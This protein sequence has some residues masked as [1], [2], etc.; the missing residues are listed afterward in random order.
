MSEPI[1][2]ATFTKHLWI[3]GF[4][5]IACGTIPLLFR[6]FNIKKEQITVIAKDADVSGCAKEYDLTFKQIEITEHNYKEI[7]DLQEGDFVLNLS[8]DVGCIDLMMWATDR[9]ALYLDTAVE[10]WDGG[11]L[12]PDQTTSER[13]LYYTRTECLSVREYQSQ[14]GKFPT[15]ITSH[16]ANPGIVSHFVKVAL[17]NIAKDTGVV[18]NKKPST[19]Q[20]W[21][22]LSRDLGVKTIH[23]AERDTQIANIP[24]KMGE[25]QSTWSVDGFY[26]ESIQPSELGWGTNEKH[27]PKDGHRHDFGDVG[28]YLE[29]Q[30]HSVR[31]RSWTPSLGSYQGYLITHNEAI[32]I[33]DYLTVK[34]DKG[35]VEYRP[36]VQ[37][38]YL[39]CD[40]AVL[41][42][43]EL[44][45]KNY[46]YEN[47]TKRLLTYN[48]VIDGRDELGVLVAGHSKNAY[49]F[50]S[51]LT[52][53]EAK[54]ISPYNTATTLQVVSGVIGGIVYALENPNKGYL[55]C[56]EMD[57]ERI[58]EVI[59]PFLGTIKGEY[60]DWTPL[61]DRGRYFEDN[62]LDSTDP[63]QFYNVRYQ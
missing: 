4:G 61:T 27:F 51:Q 42:M 52:I 59:T 56:E 55:E 19:K 57:H 49:W 7:L 23:I 41:S 26:C 62:A 47:F 32:T 33:S 9:N 46:N 36:T 63:W 22:N 8:V 15:V 50:G 60:T 24:R 12:E 54:K 31:V 53:Q 45:G 18:L 34:S 14:I 43:N 48:E 58:M 2:Y 11:F 17:L 20:E 37:F 29:N 30:S 10:L 16:G 38:S 3:I 44:C 21:A 28:I 39:P 25:I 40:A 1:K 13:S 6:H 35:E 5:A